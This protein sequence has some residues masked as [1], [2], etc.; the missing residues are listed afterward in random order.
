MN[1][2]HGPL[3]VLATTRRDAVR[4]QI[5]LGRLVLF[6]FEHLMSELAERPELNVY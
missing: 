3:L 2:R 6:A 5:T 1:E 4:S